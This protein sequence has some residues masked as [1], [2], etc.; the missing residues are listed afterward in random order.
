MSD[1]FSVTDRS[2][3]RKISIARFDLSKGEEMAQ[4][5]DMA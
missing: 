2:G 1:Q 4:T 3:W 5:C